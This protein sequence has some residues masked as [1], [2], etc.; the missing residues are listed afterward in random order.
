VNT[1]SFQ[2]YQQQF[3]AYLRNPRLSAPPAGADKKRMR[4]YAEIVFNN[5][6]A[7]V[8]ACFPVSQ[9]VLGKRAWHKLIRGFFT[10]HASNTPIFREI[11]AQF[12]QYL[13][14]RHD[15]PAYL[16]ALAHYEWVELA[17]ASHPAQLPELLNPIDGNLLQ[18]EFMVNPTLQCL[19]YHYAVHRI[20]PRRK[21]KQPLPA[22][23]HLLVYR[24]LACAVKFVEVNAITANL[25]LLL[26]AKPSTGQAAIL[27]LAQEIG[28]PEPATLVQFGAALLQD[29]LDQAVLLPSYAMVL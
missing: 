16:P 4:V 15:I 21:P 26:E 17:V 3:A 8:S 28:H 9:K 23:V 25:I 12:L 24:N 19:S 10:E 11:P 6:H 1:P 20:A 27:Q 7:S 18:T 22:P 14:S 5:I 13:D 29:L 2:L